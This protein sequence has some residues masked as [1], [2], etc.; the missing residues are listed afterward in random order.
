MI[1][2]PD[3]WLAVGKIVAVQGL[4]GEVRVYPESDFPERFLEPGDRWLLRPNSTTPEPIRLKR[5][6]YLHGKNLY[7]VKFAGIDDRESAE[8]LIG[9]EMVVSE[10]DRLPL[11]EDEFHV[12]DLM[13][14]EVYNQADSVLLGTILDI[15]PAG[16][17]LLEVQLQGEGAKKVLIPFVKAI[18]PVVDIANRRIEI[19]PPPGLI[20]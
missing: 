15:I 18:V 14:L 16:N 1:Q 2:I 11:E 20:D 6:R 9:V 12:L 8:A 7:V 4:A 10:N 13:G 19:T 5:G 3:G 17:D